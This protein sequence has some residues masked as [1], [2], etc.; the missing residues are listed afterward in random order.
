MRW[1]LLYVRSRR[2]AASTGIALVSAA[3]LGLLAAGSDAEITRVVLALFAVTVV[4]SVAATSLAGPD[5]SLERTAALD[6]RP[7]RAVHAVTVCVVA[8]G[9]VAALGMPA[10]VV[11]RNAIGLT[12]LAA[13]GVVVLGGGLAW[14]VPMVWTVVGVTAILAARTPPAP[15]LTW[16]VQPAHSGAAT[17]AACVLGAVGLVAYALAGPSARSQ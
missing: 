10:D 4:V 5:P 12:G 6:W 11:V 17:V 13:L 8:A 14:C 9:S 15:L 7:R 1:L 16:P 3:A 2:A